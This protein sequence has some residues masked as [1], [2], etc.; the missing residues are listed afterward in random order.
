MPSSS[1]RRQGM[2]ECAVAGGGVSLRGAEEGGR[3]D[4]S[5]LK[6]SGGEFG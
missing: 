5:R 3:V 4:E 2:L 1:E 6:G